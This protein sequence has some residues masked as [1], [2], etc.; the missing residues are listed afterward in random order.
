MQRACANSQAGE[1]T[2]RVVVDSIE[3]TDFTQYVKNVQGI[4]INLDIHYI[5]VVLQ[6]LKDTDLTKQFISNG[7]VFIWTDKTRICEM[8]DIMEEKKFAY[9]E[10]IVFSV[11][12]IVKL[13]SLIKELSKN[14]MGRKKAM[15]GFFK[16]Q[17]DPDSPVSF[18][19]K[20]VT[21]FL[22]TAPFELSSSDSVENYLL[23][24][25][26]E[27]IATNKRTLLVFRRVG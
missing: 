8:I 18:S 9:V 17:N 14:S 11:F 6:K 1:L 13:S 5:D 20:E 15:E 26:S 27:F 12:D 24:F 25:S 19:W 16:I 23:K 21:D 7:L 4:F 2:R 10:N 3:T 22:S